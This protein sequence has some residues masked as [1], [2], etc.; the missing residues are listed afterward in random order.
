MKSEEKTPSPWED[1]GES[2]SSSKDK[3]ET[4]AIARQNIKPPAF[5]KSE[6]K[7]PNSRM[8]T[9]KGHSP[10]EKIKEVYHL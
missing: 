6:E 7:I 5:K 4:Q 8:N 1:I 10:L 3:E 2:T 9:K